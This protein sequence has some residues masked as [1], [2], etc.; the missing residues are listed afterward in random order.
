MQYNLIGTRLSRNKKEAISLS[1][2][3]FLFL[4]VFSLE[5]HAQSFIQSLDLELAYNKTT[6]LIFPY[7]V[8]SVDRGSRDILVSK[9]G[10][11]ENILLVKAARAGFESTNLT[12]ITAD[13]KFYSFLVHYV[14]DPQQL[15]LSFAGE[16]PDIFKLGTFL[17][18]SARTDRMKISLKGIYIHRNLLWFR[19]DI[20][21]HSLIDFKPGYIRFFIADRERLFRTA[22]QEVELTP[23][24]QM[25]VASIPARSTKSFVFGF[26]SFTLPRDKSMMV[27]IG[28]DQG[29]RLLRLPIGYQT[30]LRARESGDQKTE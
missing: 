18:L 20:G 12:V 8:S 7:P 13:G 24:Y 3:F 30:I 9:N 6:S 2:I 22:E 16:S 5:T 11:N 26:G 29:G 27:E 23:I 4:S 21:N 1:P 25:A 14:E 15:N 28:E 19:F 17:H 10:R